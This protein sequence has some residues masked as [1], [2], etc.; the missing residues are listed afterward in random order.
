MSKNFGKMVYKD[1]K[2]HPVTTVATCVAAVTLIP[3]CAIRGL[4]HAKAKNEEEM[5]N[6]Q[7]KTMQQYAKTFG[8]NGQQT[9][10]PT[11]AQPQILQK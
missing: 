2:K 8:S 5:N 1:L 10:I 4:G 7:L 3:Y 6:I 9:M 11:T